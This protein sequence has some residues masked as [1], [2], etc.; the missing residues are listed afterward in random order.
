MLFVHEKDFSNLFQI[1]EQSNNRLL[2]TLAHLLYANDLL[3]T[4]CVRKLAS[5]RPATAL[6]VNLAN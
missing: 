5:H 4:G 6:H 2:R 1:V 3:A